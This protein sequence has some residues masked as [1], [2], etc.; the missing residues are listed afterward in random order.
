MPSTHII[1]M[2]TQT[3]AFLCTEVWVG[4]YNLIRESYIIGFHMLSW[5]LLSRQLC[6]WCPNLCWVQ[7]SIWDVHP[8]KSE[9]VIGLQFANLSEVQQPL[10]SMTCR[11]ASC[12]EC[13]H[14][15]WMSSSS[16]ESTSNTHFKS[17]GFSH[18]C[19]FRFVFLHLFISSSEDTRFR[20]S[21]NHIR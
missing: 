18:F 2:Q 11:L 1:H 20:S 15:K 10:F 5:I 4:I 17:Q 16:I 21:F 14:C 3:C 12:S 9:S 13:T 8:G 19:I 7:I 6:Q